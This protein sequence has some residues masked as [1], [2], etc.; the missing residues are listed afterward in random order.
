ME[1]PKVSYKYLKSFYLERLVLNQHNTKVVP[2]YSEHSKMLKKVKEDYEQ[3]VEIYL[4]CIQP[5][6][7]FKWLKLHT[8]VG[9]KIIQDDCEPHKMAVAFECF[10]KYAHNLLVSPWKPIYRQIQENT[11]FFRSKIS[12]YLDD[13]NRIFERM[14][15]KRSKQGVWKLKNIADRD[16]LLEIAVD[17]SIASKE[18]IFIGRIYDVAKSFNF[19]LK[20][21]YVARS[22][23]LG[24]PD[25]CVAQMVDRM[26][27]ET[28]SM[29][30]NIEWE[31]C[32][33]YDDESCLHVENTCDYEDL[34][35]PGYNTV[36]SPISDIPCNPLDEHI[37]ASF[38]AVNKVPIPPV[39]TKNSSLAVIKNAPVEK[40][41]MLQA[42]KRIPATQQYSTALPDEVQ[43]DM[44]MGKYLDY[45][46][47]YNLRKT[48][49]S[50]ANA[51]KVSAEGRRTEAVV[52][53][54]SMWICIHCTTSNTKNDHVCKECAKNDEEDSCPVCSVDVS[55]NPMLP[56]RHRK[57]DMLPCH[58]NSADVTMQT[59]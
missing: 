2:T 41:H 58:R 38:L 52:T 25:E 14:G 33:A 13:T 7:K 37:E 8:S 23:Y 54:S 53:R 59:T 45:S 30:T 47:K 22:T 29:V 48:S 56:S 27:P 36:V 40:L 35:S 32:K 17:M 6:S 1:E 18:C 51:K 21:V 43:S 10:E 26:V 46:E 24:S 34:Y 55:N 28:S 4:A 31:A 39:R 20:Q 11:G 49:S 44:P 42:T 9:G 3:N 57:G 15:Y 19:S 12:Q 5:E 50:D 16:T